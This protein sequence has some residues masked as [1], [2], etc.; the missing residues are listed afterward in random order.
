[1]RPDCANRLF[2]IIIFTDCIMPVMGGIEATKAIR[3]LS[4]L[5]PNV[6]VTGNGLPEDVAALMSCGSD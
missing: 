2:D 6:A 3:G 4:F 5:C 1:M